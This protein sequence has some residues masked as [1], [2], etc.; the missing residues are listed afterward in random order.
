MSDPNSLLTITGETDAQKATPKDQVSGEVMLTIT[1]DG[2]ISKQLCFNVN[3][4]R[5]WSGTVSRGDYDGGSGTKEDPY[6]IH[7]ARQLISAFKDNEPNEYYKLTKDIW[8]NDNL[9]DN[10]GEPKA[11]RS[12]WNH[13][14]KRDQNNW[15]AHLDGDGHL[16][17]GLFSINA[18][19]LIEAIRSGASIENTGFV[20]C[21]AWSP[22]HE[23]WIINATGDYYS[24][25]FG[26]LAPSIA[27]DAV[28]RNCLFAGAMKERRDHLGH[29][30]QLVVNNTED[31]TQMGGLVHTIDDASTPITSPILEDCVVSVTAKS[32]ISGEKPY[33]ALITHHPRKETATAL[34]ARRVLVLND[35]GAT[36]LL[37]PDG[38]DDLFIQNYFKSLDLENCFFPIG[39]LAKHGVHNG[40]TNGKSVD[41]MTNG[42]FFTGEGFDKWTAQQGRFPM[43]KS[44]A[45]TAYGKLI[46]LP[47]YTSADNG[48]SN[49]NYLLDFTPSR[50]TWLSTNDDA[51]HPDADIRVLE[52]KTAEGSA[53]LV[54]TMDGAQMTTPLTTAA[55]I[56]AGITF[57]DV[58]A[59]KFCLAHYDSND[60]GSISLSELKSVTLEQLQ[61]DMQEDDGNAFDNDGD[62][63]ASFPEFR[64]FAGISALGTAF[65]E[66]DQL[67][68]I[69]L[70]GNITTLGNDAFRGTTSMTAFTL[71]VTMTSVGE[72]PF[73]NSGLQNYSVEA[74]HNAFATLSGILTNND[75]T[76]LISY[77]NGRTAT[78]I[79]IDEHITSVASHAIYKLPKVDSV[80]INTKDYDYETVLQLQENAV[81]HASDGKQMLF[82]VEDATD[83]E[84]TEAPLFAGRRIGTSSNSNGH[85]LRQ[86]KSDPQW[87]GKQIEPFFTLDVSARSKD[88]NGNYWA[89]MYIGFDT[90]LPDD[91][92]PYIVDKD[93]TDGK[94]ATLVLRS[95]SRK[96]PKRTPIVV[97][98]K[99]AKQY[100]LFASKEEKFDELPMSENLLDG[101]N[102]NGLNINQGDAND[103]GCLTLGLNKSGKV[104]FFIYKGRNKIPAFRSYIS[105]NKVNDAQA[106]L[107]DEETTGI[108]D[109]ETW[110]NAENEK[111]Y[112]LKGQRLQDPAKGINAVKGR[113]FIK[114]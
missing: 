44:F 2:G 27:S 53:W 99:E 70:S 40:T 59:K 106:L 92:T 18:F 87:D 103:G 47:I 100:K 43:L 22:E 101:I 16:V 1:A 66:K 25:P 10:T 75:S 80:F 8:F 73:H 94:K 23:E 102:R 36:M 105:V 58:E 42:T 82:F 45:Q 78:S 85:L 69:G 86:Y 76:Q 37:A 12:E 72:H 98:A 90:V 39:Y 6:L 71:P 21:L 96:I 93:K 77:P 5:R 46:S 62:L 3:T 84:D 79:D 54:R 81:T 61:Q 74:D 111:Y 109:I 68:E 31:H 56:E 13:E 14:S 110:R 38:Y 83:D 34:A 51:I 113:L 50:A 49:M 24:L 114:K 26:F 11:E 89:T 17:R 112:N 88:A 57:S 95:I 9:L 97:K 19:G 67:Q 35:N 33:R 7:N 48:L 104:G 4:L 64:Y 29:P 65:Q 63:I 91:L 60:D 108:A 30:S 20:D 32:V 15:Y 28:V 55:T 41:E 107:L 52:P